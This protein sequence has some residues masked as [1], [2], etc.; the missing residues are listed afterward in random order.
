MLNPVT[1]LGQHRV[2]NIQRI[3]CHKIHAHALGS[4]QAHNQLNA[5]NQHLGRFVEQQM[6]FVKKE[7]Q[8]GLL[9]IA[10]LGQLL[11]Q[12]RQHPQQ[13][14]GVQARRI[15]KLVSGQDVD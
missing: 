11:K 9:R 14:G 15:Q 5:F 7:D 10:N 4:N 8:L 1:Q 2:G 12:F 6:R 3:L 13:K